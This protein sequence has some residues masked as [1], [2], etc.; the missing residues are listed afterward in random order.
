MTDKSFSE[1]IRTA[2]DDERQAVYEEVMNKAI[3]DQNK[4]LEEYMESIE[5]ENKTFEPCASDVFSEQNK[6]KLFKNKSAMLDFISFA[7]CQAA[8]FRQ[9]YMQDGVL[10][11]ELVYVGES[12]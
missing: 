1:F 7:D 3:E 2:P 4:L 12:K 8:Q 10:V 5:Q 9:G 11:W 6:R